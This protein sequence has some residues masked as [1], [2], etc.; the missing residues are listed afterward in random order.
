[1]KFTYFL[2]ENSYYQEF[3]KFLILL[4]LCNIYKN[5]YSYCRKI[6]L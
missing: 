6:Y 2:Y 5:E 3:I 4:G 1:M